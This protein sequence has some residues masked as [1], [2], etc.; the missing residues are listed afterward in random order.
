MKYALLVASM[1]AAVAAVPASA[2]VTLDNKVLR[3]EVKVAA[4]GTRTTALVSTRNVAPGGTAVYVMTYRNGTAKPVSDLVIANQVPRDVIYAGPASGSPAPAVSVDGG[5]TFGPIASASVRGVNGA[6][7]A[8]FSDV[9]HVRWIVAGP[10]AP[11]SSGSV[12][13]RAKVR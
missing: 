1:F 11:G 7:P 12:S 6:R 13:Y 5:K 8:Q 4:D 2:Q 10:V 9:T 3:E